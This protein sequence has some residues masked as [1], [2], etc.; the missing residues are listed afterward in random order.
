MKL[1]PQHGLAAARRTYFPAFLM[2]VFE[3]LAPL[4][5]K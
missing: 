2:K 4:R 1:D 3:T 5:S